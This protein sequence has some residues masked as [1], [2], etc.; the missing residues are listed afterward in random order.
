[1]VEVEGPYISSMIGKAVI[2][3]TNFNNVSK[4]EIV[5]I[6]SING[7]IKGAAGGALIG[8]VLGPEGAAVGAVLGGSIGLIFGPD[9]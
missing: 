3:T 6:P 5:V 2:T 1:M 4:T 9:D 7:A 8:S